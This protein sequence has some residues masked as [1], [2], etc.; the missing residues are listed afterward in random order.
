LLKYLHPGDIDAFFPSTEKLLLAE[1]PI[2]E[3]KAII[4]PESRIMSLRPLELYQWF[5][6]YSDTWENC[7]ASSLTKQ[8]HPI[9]HC[10]RTFYREQQLPATLRSVQLLV[11]RRLKHR[12][13]RGM[14]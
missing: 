4:D 7:H 1:K 3:I 2:L 13:K 14:K 11:V 8:R 5:N 10:R 6:G 9:S 12:I